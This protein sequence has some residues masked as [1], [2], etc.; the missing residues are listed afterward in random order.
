MPFL[1]WAH[2]RSRAL[3]AHH[4]H[5]WFSLDWNSESIGEIG[6]NSARAAPLGLPPIFISNDRAAVYE[7]QVLAPGIEVVIAK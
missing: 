4:K 3:T 6:M 1:C 5:T 7:A 2:T